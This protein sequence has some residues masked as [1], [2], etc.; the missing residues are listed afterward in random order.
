[1]TQM[2]L[3][4]FT[5]CEAMH[6]LYEFRL[7][8]SI[9]NTFFQIL[10]ALGKDDAR[11]K[12][13]I[14]SLTDMQENCGLGVGAGG[15]E[16]YMSQFNNVR[17]LNVHNWL[18]EVLANTGVIGGAIWGFIFYL[19]IIFGL[20]PSSRSHIYGSS[21]LIVFIL[22]PLWQSI[23]SS[24]IQFSLFWFFMAAFIRQIDARLNTK[25]A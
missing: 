3:P 25:Y 20:R 11:F 5:V 19:L 7:I 6:L 24:M 22:F 23:C 18:G 9:A 16:S 15:I 10:D 17:V 8:D 2:Q 4:A 21:V 12:L 1:M 14:H 13:L